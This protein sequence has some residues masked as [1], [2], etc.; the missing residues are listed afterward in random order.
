MRN[1]KIRIYSVYCIY[2]IVII[3]LVI[4]TLASLICVTIYFINISIILK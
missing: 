2:A 3:L 1:G 4:E